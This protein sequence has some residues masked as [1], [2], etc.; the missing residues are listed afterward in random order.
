MQS[1]GK[2]LIQAAPRCIRSLAPR[3]RSSARLYVPMVH[4]DDNFN[5]D[6]P[7]SRSNQTVGTLLSV[8]STEI[9][10]HDSDDLLSLRPHVHSSM[11]HMADSRHMLAIAQ[12]LSLDQLQWERKPKHGERRE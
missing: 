4:V 8:Q 6:L 5:H 3:V 12:A 1:A 7:N 11:L 9:D 2:T 10:S